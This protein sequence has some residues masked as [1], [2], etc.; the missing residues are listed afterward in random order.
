MEHDPEGYESLQSHKRRRHVEPGIEA[1]G[2]PV[3]MENEGLPAPRQQQD[4]EMPVEAPVESASV[5]RGAAAVA[6]NE[7]R[8]R[9]RLGAE[10]KRGQKDDVHDVHPRPRRGPGWIRGGVTS[11][12]AHNFSQNR[13]KKSRQQFME[14]RPRVLMFL[15]I[16]F[17][18]ASLRQRTKKTSRCSY[19]YEC[20]IQPASA[21]A[22]MKAKP[23]TLRD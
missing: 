5:K 13:R 7:Q 3:A 6:D 9:L 4:V 17:V 19:F 11:V 23:K 12:K 15:F 10:G 8:A 1:N 18:A 2:A 16:L 22:S 14:A 20:G 21:G